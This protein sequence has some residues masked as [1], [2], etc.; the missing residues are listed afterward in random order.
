MSASCGLQGRGHRDVSLCHHPPGSRGGSL[1][2]KHHKTGQPLARVSWVL[3]SLS[4]PWESW[5]GS[6]VRAVALVSCTGLG[7]KEHGEGCGWDSAFLSRWPLKVKVQGNVKRMDLILF[8]KA[9]LLC[10]G[11]GGLCSLPALQ[12]FGQ[13]LAL[14]CW[15]SPPREP[16]ELAAGTAAGS[17]GR[18]GQHCRAEWLL[19]PSFA[20]FTNLPLF[21][22]FLTS[23]LQ[24]HPSKHLLKRRLD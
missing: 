3:C 24:R 21:C 23:V 20:P 4:Q 14:R 1:G 10:Q 12:T 8:F 15:V 13:Q 6:V 19:G 17:A 22:S 7:D 5:Q 9:R 18:S 2:S 11:G 16:S